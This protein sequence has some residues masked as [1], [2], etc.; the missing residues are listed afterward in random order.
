[1]VK[2]VLVFDIDGT[3]CDANKPVPEFLAKTLISLSV[4]NL[5][6]FSSGKPF[7]Y[8]SGFL[9]QLSIRDCLIVSENGALISYGSSFPPRKKRR[10]CTSSDPVAELESIKERYLFNLELNVWF[11]PNDVN[12][13][14]FPEEPV[15]ILNLVGLIDMDDYRHV[16]RYI[17]SDSVDYVPKGV[18]KGKALEVLCDE[19]DFNREDFFVFGDGE[20][21]IPMFV[22][23]DNSIG[24]KNQSISQYCKFFVNDFSELNEFLRKEF[25]L[26]AFVG[27]ELS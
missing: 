24:V 5:L 27:K 14:V 19:M 23:S 9:R 26:E 12:L 3:L 2:K 6:V 11:Q 18:D 16:V 10:L 25:L 17:H 8:I 21:D 20:N 22:F 15:D 1:M 13:T 7:A 4:D